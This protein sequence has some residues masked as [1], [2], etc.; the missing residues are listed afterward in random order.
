MLECEV[1]ASM[2]AHSWLIFD[3]ISTVN[4]TTETRD[5]C[6]W[7]L[8][9]L[10]HVV[11]WTVVYLLPE[12]FVLV[13]SFPFLFIIL[14]LM[15]KSTVITH[16]NVCKALWVVPLSNIC[17]WDILFRKKLIHPTQKDPN[18]KS[19]SGIRH[20]SSPDIPISKS[21]HDQN[22]GILQPNTANMSKRDEV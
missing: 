6:I 11:I 16:V 1:Q 7:V 13:H 5:L 18:I 9:A 22:I 14:F 10:L 19:Q 4:L 21:P 15:W 2:S 17:S 8:W 20:P 12:E 3:S